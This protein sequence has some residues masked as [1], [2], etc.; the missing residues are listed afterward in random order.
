M[1]LSIPGHLPMLWLLAWCICGTPNSRS[2]C[3]WLFSA[4]ILG[5]LPCPVVSF[6]DVF[7]CCLMKAYSFPKKKRN[8]RGSGGE[9]ILRGAE[10]S[11]GR[12]TV[13]WMH[14][15]SIKNNITICLEK[16]IEEGLDTLTPV[17]FRTKHQNVQ[18]VR[19]IIGSSFCLFGKKNIT[20]FSPSLQNKYEEGLFIDWVFR[21]S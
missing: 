2:V 8:G 1:G 17:T 6:F 20:Y 21:N 5:F 14:L 13:V 7:S 12:E 15:F 19:I 9:G 16:D 10:K 4:S 18:S 3:V 11:W